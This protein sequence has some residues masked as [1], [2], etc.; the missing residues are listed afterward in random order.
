M[1][2]IDLDKLTEVIMKE[3]EFFVKNAY[4]ANQRDR[5]YATVKDNVKNAI[6]NHLY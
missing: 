5:E 2:K 6:R 1:E 3:V 4:Q